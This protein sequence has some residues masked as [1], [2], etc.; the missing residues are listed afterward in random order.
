MVI[1]VVDLNKSTINYINKFNQMMKK[2]LFKNKNIINE[3]NNEIRLT[4]SN[5]HIP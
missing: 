4:L 1:I 2:E 5:I 3:I